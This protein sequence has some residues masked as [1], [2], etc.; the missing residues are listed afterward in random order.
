MHWS[1][2]LAQFDFVITH[3][4]GKASRKPNTLLRREDHK[5]NDADDNTNRVM[6]SKEKSRVMAM[7]RGS[8]TV[9]G[10]KELLRRIKACEGKDEKVVE[11]LAMVKG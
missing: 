6:L 2:F 4:L 8:V 9:L 7:G 5:R 10:D 3:R 1:L 11:A